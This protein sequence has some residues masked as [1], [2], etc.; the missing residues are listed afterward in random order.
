MHAQLNKRLRGR[1][2]IPDEGEKEIMQTSTSFAPLLGLENVAP[3][4]FELADTES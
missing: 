4:I 1:W 3:R 2:D